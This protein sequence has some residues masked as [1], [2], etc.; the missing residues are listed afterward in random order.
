VEIN[1]ISNKQLQSELNDKLTRQSKIIQKCEKLESINE[2]IPSEIFNLEAEFKEN[3]AELIKL[4]D[5]LEDLVQEILIVNEEIYRR[6]EENIHIY[7]HEELEAAGQL[8][9]MFQTV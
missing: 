3:E 2:T 9:F 8:F 7:T 6:A 5:E 4:D 1:E